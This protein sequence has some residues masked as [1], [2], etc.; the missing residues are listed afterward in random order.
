MTIAVDRFRDWSSI[1]S[2]IYLPS[3]NETEFL[4]EIRATAEHTF[5]LMLALIRNTK[6]AFIHTESGE[7]NRD[8]FQGSELYKKKVGILGLG[9]LGKIVAEYTSAF[10][11]DISDR[12]INR[13]N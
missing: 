4:K 2:G 8:L 10:G 13:Q 12:V 6:R 7:W 5:G 11:M 3:P 1:E 9:R